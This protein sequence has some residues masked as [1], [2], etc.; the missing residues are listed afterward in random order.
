VTDV[1]CGR[2]SHRVSW[3]H[4]S[5]SARSAKLTR[6]GAPGGERVEKSS[7]GRSQSPTR[8][9]GVSWWVKQMTCRVRM[10]CRKWRHLEVSPNTYTLLCNWHNRAEYIG[11]QPVWLTVPAPGLLTLWGREPVHLMTRAM[12]KVWEAKSTCSKSKGKGKEKVND[13]RKE[14]W[15]EELEKLLATCRSR[16]LLSFPPPLFLLLYLFVLCCCE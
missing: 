5:G 7:R 13:L 12:Q 2:Q 15:R 10:R 3:H 1:S 11:H 16:S 14:G 4:T 6:V 9:L 8:G